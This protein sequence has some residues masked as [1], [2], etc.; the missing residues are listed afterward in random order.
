MIIQ[1][2]SGVGAKIRKYGE[3]PPEASAIEKHMVSDVKANMYDL[4]AAQL[5]ASA[6]A[7]EY[8]DLQ[9]FAIMMVRQGLAGCN[10]VSIQVA[11]DALLVD[12]SAMLVQ[13]QKGDLVI[14]CFRGTE[15]KNAINWATD[16]TTRQE[17][18]A[19]AGYVHGGFNRA[20]VVLWPLLGP[21]LTCALKRTNICEALTKEVTPLLGAA[22]QIGAERTTPTLA[23]PATPAPATP[24]PE[25]S[26][27]TPVP[28]QAPVAC[29]ITGHSL[30]GALAALAG[31][32]AYTNALVQATGILDSLRG[33]YTF[34]QPMIG[35]PQFAAKLQG[36]LGQNLFRHVYGR[37]IVPR[38][39]PWT[40]G[41]YAHVGE[42]YVSTNDGWVYQS[43]SA[44]QAY[45]A[46]ASSLVGIG[47][48]IFQEV[49][50]IDWLSL[51]FSWEDHSPDNYLRTSQTLPPEIELI[52]S[53]G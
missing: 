28:T 10:C 19:G 9:T 52:G 20:L 21:L 17:P 40:M 12:T 35:N 51:P 44:S 45:T 27:S 18:L 1:G 48:F 23:T 47:A 13:S 26:G 33:I 37:D 4:Q 22:C 31:A 50:P 36:T 6:S 3:L 34:G 8:S 14:L 30:G 41:S 25:T 15:P 43:V 46:V 29:F 32:Y 39:P 49:F 16:A 53:V 11:N 7:W 42:E 5:L 38:L 2:I 24:T